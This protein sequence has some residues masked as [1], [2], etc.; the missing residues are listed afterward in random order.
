M[1]SNAGYNMTRHA[2]NKLSSKKV[3]SIYIHVLKRKYTPVVCIDN[4]GLTVATFLY[5]KGLLREGRGGI[6]KIA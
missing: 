3:I 4:Y 2:F 1:N 5:N 6:N